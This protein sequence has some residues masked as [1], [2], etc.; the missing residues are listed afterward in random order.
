MHTARRH[1]S[2]FYEGVE[3]RLARAHALVAKPREDIDIELIVRED[4]KILEVFRIGAGVVVEPVQ[5]I[6]DAR[7][8]EQRQRLG[9]ARR[10]SVPLAIASSMAARSGVSNTS[11]NGR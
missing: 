7:G 3:A 1:I 4:H 8:T 5:R 9:R 6:I 11:R 2:R 10:C